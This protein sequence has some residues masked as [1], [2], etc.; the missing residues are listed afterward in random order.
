ME[1]TSV[2]AID[3]EDLCSGGPAVE[4]AILEAFGIDGLGIM[5]VRNVPQ[6]SS[7]RERVCRAAWAFGKQPPAVQR[8]YE[9]PPFFQRGWDKGAGPVRT[10]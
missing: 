3:C 4:S 6:L 8:Q 5:A 2:V 7:A 10:L 9:V 1:K